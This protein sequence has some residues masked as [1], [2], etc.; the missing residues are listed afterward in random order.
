MALP[1]AGSSAIRALCFGREPYS[2]AGYKNT[3]LSSP[4]LQ[5]WQNFP[6]WGPVRILIQV[7]LSYE[8]PNPVSYLVDEAVSSSVMVSIHLQKILKYV[9]GKFTNFAGRWERAGEIKLVVFL[10]IL[11][12]FIWKTI[13][14]I[15]KLGKTWSL[16]WDCRG[17]KQTSGR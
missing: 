11:C 6:L 10:Q 5:L 3:A 17:E 4:N 9:F 15:K 16:L 1:I 8:D 14:K 13:R 2:S 12:L 7:R